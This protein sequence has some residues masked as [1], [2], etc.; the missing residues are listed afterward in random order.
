LILNNKYLFIVIAY[1]FDIKSTGV[2][3]E[4]KIIDL[5]QMR[6]LIAT[7]M[8]SSLEERSTSFT[9]H[10]PF[11]GILVYM[12]YN[13]LHSTLFRYVESRTASNTF[14]IDQLRASS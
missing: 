3:E 12:G 4:L 10:C 6:F 7:E 8:R 11:Y 2:S 13:S 14:Q 1:A 5:M 9:L